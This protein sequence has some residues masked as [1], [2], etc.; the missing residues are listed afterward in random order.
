MKILQKRN[1]FTPKKNLRSNNGKNKGRK[2]NK[3]IQ[4][5]NDQIKTYKY[6]QK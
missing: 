6:Y 4:K 1:T 3:R 2:T 5:S